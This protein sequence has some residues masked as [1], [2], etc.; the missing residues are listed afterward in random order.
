V[1]CWC[2]R[3]GRLNARVVD[4]QV[5]REGDTVVV[6]DTDPVGVGAPADDVPPSNVHYRV[7]CRMHHRRGDLGGA[8]GQGQLTLDV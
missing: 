6:A 3:P 4:G 5:V 8:A 1:L 2:G 7:L